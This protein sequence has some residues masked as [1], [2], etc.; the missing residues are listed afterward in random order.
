MLANSRARTIMMLR[1]DLREAY[2]QIERKGARFEG[3]LVN[4][5]QEAE[6]AMSQIAGYDPS[7]YTLLELGKDLRDTSEQL[8]LSMSSMSKK[9]ASSKGKK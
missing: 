9:T 4:A 2:K 5:K 1:N 3:A 8:Y 6:I 7:D